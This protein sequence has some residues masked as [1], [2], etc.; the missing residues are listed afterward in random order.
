MP[1]A[2]DHGHR[3]ILSFAIQTLFIGFRIAMC[4]G[5]SLFRRTRKL[6]FSLV[7]EAKM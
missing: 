4:A 2:S 7:N 1:L 6:H 3:A 5:L